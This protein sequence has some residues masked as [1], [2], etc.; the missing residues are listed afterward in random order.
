M[1]RADK[2]LRIVTLDEN[3]E[4]FKIRTIHGDEKFKLFTKDSLETVNCEDIVELPRLSKGK[5]TIP[6]R[7]GN[8]LIELFEI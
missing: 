2:P 3:D 7:K 8:V 1:N 6:V 4:I 5:K